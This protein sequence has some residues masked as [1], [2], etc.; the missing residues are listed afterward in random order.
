MPPLKRSNFRRFLGVK[1]PIW[2][3]W[4]VERL[5][6][7]SLKQSVCPKQIAKCTIPIGTCPLSAYSGSDLD[8]GLRV[9][10][11]GGFVVGCFAVRH[12]WAVSKN[13]SALTSLKR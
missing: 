4:A 3:P 2:P 11:S 13:P 12:L 6:R 10:D 7:Q 8:F 5:R 9:Y 1:V